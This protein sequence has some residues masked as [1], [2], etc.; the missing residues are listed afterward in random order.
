L[1]GGLGFLSHFV[2]NKEYIRST[3]FKVLLILKIDKIIVSRLDTP[4]NK[5]DFEFI[6]PLKNKIISIISKINVKDKS[7]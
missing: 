7:R 2:L 1:S 3:Y 5:N 4:I 6:S